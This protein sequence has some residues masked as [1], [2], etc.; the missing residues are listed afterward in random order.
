MTAVE[1]MAIGLFGKAC[2]FLERFDAFGC[3]VIRHTTEIGAQGD[4]PT[5][6]TFY[7]ITQHLCDI[8]QRLQVGHKLHLNLAGDQKIQ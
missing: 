6:I 1:R 4:K 3:V 2:P 8:E 7:S 5:R